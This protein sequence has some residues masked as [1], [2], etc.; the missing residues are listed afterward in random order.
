MGFG[1]AVGCMVHGA[2]CR[3]GV[4]DVAGVT[5]GGIVIVCDH[6]TVRQGVI[7]RLLP[8]WT[9]VIVTFVLDATAMAK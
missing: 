5:I 2:S 4:F 8:G 9:V 7:I 3:R 6:G 1:R